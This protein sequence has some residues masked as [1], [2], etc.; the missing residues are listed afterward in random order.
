MKG[1]DRMP[2]KMH[3]EHVRKP[4]ARHAI[5]HVGKLARLSLVPPCYNFRRGIYASAPQM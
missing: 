5:F 4:V 1:I 2:A 3:G